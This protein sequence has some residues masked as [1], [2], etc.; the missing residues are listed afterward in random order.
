MERA[1][2]A[3]ANLVTDW[4][5]AA[6]QLLTGQSPVIEARELEVVVDFGQGLRVHQDV[7]VTFEAPRLAD[8]E[9]WVP[10]RWAPTGRSRL[11]PSFV[12][13]LELRRLRADD[14]GAALRLFGTYSIPLGL[15]GRFGDGFRGQRLAQEAIRMLVTD[16]A[17]RV[18]RLDVE[19]PVDLPGPVYPEVLRDR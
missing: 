3:E 4:S 10:M 15:V 14:E 17:R 2:E 16:L 1:I 9:L 19:E 7:L 18:D 5:I 6:Q 13:V 8:G 11:L 12:G